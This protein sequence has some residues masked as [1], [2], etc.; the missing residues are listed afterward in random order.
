LYKQNFS[1]TKQNESENSV[2]SHERAVLIGFILDFV[3]QMLCE[4]FQNCPTGFYSAKLTVN[5]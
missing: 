3:P 5:H 2:I 1:G 4:D